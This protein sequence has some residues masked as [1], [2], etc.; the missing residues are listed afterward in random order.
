MVKITTSSI[1]VIYLVSCVAF[2]CV[3]AMC[4][5]LLDAMVMFH[6]LSFSVFIKNQL[7]NYSKSKKKS[8]CS[9]IPFIIIETKS[10]HRHQ[11]SICSD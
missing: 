7:G 5:A 9:S 4:N 3:C 6:P 2:V 10:L 8:W 11:N 1:K